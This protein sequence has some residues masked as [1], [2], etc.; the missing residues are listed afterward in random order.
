MN[1]KL[2][3]ERILNNI[4]TIF[5]KETKEKIF[6]TR[7]VL[8]LINEKIISKPEDIKDMCK[9][10]LELLFYLFHTLKGTGLSVG[11]PNATNLAQEAL[12]AIS[13]CYADILDIKTLHNDLVK[14]ISSIE[15]DLLNVVDV[16]VQFDATDIQ[17]KLSKDYQGKIAVID[18]DIVLLDIIKQ[19]LELDGYDVKLFNDS[20]VALRWFEQNSNIDLIITDVVMPVHDGFELAKRIKAIAEY[21]N[22]AMLFLTAESTLDDKLKGFDLGADDYLAKPF[23]LEEL[24]ARV[25]SITSRRKLYEKNTLQDPLTGIHNRKYLFLK[26]KEEI[27]RN[28]RTKGIFSVC[29]IDLDLFK[30]VND[31]YGHQVGDETIKELVKMIGDSVRTTDTLARYGGEEFVILLLEATAQNAK[32]VVDRIRQKIANAK[33]SP[34]NCTESFSVT[35][36]AGIAEFDKDGET[37]QVLLSKAD[38]ALYRAKFSG[39]NM[40]CIN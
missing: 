7:S 37:E 23:E 27:L 35:F 5:V 11:F 17:L 32:V 15:N 8:Y 3:S 19:R 40:V 4:R 14:I 34:E 10:Q 26:L 13:L 22:T 28:K 21:K 25:N 20:E 38:H 16:G 31:R 39:R 33:I 18:D 24:A 2:L 6:K 1:C 30:H 9:D 29:M 12:Q 36:S